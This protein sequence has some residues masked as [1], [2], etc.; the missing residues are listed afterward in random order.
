MSNNKLIHLK[1]LSHLKHLIKLKAAWNQIHKAFDFEPPANLEWVDYTGN[2]I[3]KIENADRN[4]FLKCLI[5]DS[6]N[7][8]QIEG[9]KHNKC[10]R[11]LSLNGNNID[12]IENL[13]DLHIEEL[14]LQQNRLRKIT[15][16]ERLP[17]LKT[18]DVSKNQIS[19]LKGLHRTESLRFLKIQ[20]NNIAKI[21]QLSNIENLP[22]LTDVDLSCNPI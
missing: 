8:Q 21:G 2:A 17:N 11:T 13:D 19:K 12:T 7:I 22:L 14:F 18:L 16:L 6:N 1:D 10:L 15:G 4:V 9:L 3:N 5:L 20:L